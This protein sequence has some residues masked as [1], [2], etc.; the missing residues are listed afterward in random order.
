MILRITKHGETVLRRKG[1]LL[2]LELFRRDHPGLLSDMWETMYAAH[3]VGLAAPQVG[4]SLRLAVIDVQPDSPK[5]RKIVLVNPEIVH[6]EGSVLEEEG[7]LSI[8][9]LYAKVKRAAKVKVKAFN[10]HG[11]PVEITGQG[12]LA[13]ALQH[14]IDHLNGRLFIDHLPFLQRFKVHR[15]IRQLRKNWK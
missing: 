5:S 1:R 15:L 10:E 3:G 8:P 2:D 14:E 9:G 7:C 12:L 11:I 4:L 6:K 13:R